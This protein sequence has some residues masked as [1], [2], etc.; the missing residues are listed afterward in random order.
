MNASVLHPKA[1]KAKEAS[2]KR[3]EQRAKWREAI[4]NARRKHKIHFWSNGHVT[5]CYRRDVAN[6][7]EIST[8]IKNPN[9]KP[10]RL[11]AQFYA[12]ER[13]ANSNRVLIHTGKDFAGRKQSIKDWCGKAFH[14]G[15]IF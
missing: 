14:S 8:T 2:E 1:I 10:D 11:A 7:F 5:I 6:I 13:F 4:A 15:R 9:D 3:A 12:L